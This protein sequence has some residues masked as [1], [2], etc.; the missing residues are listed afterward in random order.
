MPKSSKEQID[1]DEKKVIRELE[2]NAKQS[3]DKILS[4]IEKLIIGCM[5]KE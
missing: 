2:K 5:K 1:L 3:I 4:N